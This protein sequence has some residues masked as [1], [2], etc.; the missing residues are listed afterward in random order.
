MVDYS[1]KWINWARKCPTL[2]K[3]GVRISEGTAYIKGY[4][5]DVLGSTVIDV[6]KP[7]SVLSKS[8]TANIPFAMELDEGQ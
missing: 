1:E 6:D 2:D 4:D 7:R 8:R 3:M 5:I